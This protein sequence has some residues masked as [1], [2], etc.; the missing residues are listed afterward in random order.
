MFNIY[1]PRFNV[2]FYRESRTC[3]RMAWGWS[4][5]PLD[6]VLRRPFHALSLHYEMIL[7]RRS[8]PFSIDEQ[9]NYPVA[10]SSSACFHFN[11]IWAGVCRTR[12]LYI[13]NSLAQPLET[14]ELEE[15]HIIFSVVRLSQGEGDLARSYLSRLRSQG[16]ICIATWFEFLFASYANLKC[17]PNKATKCAKKPSRSSQAARVA[18]DTH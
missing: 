6:D 1:Q 18:T 11:S 13:R 3:P 8:S 7:G 2:T 9:R 12:L 10:Q 16:N 4:Q 14:L 5:L 15:K 17:T